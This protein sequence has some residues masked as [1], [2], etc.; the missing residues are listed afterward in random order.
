M[1][2]FTLFSSLFSS[3]RGQGTGRGRP[4][5]EALEDRQLLSSALYPGQVLYPGGPVVSSP[6]G[7]FQL[8]LRADGDLVEYGPY[9]D[10]LWESYTGGRGVRYATLQTDGNLVLYG[11]PHADGSL[12]AVKGFGTDHHPGDVLRVQD[13][14][15]VVI[16]QGGAPGGNPIWATNTAGYDADVFLRPGVSSSSPNLNFTLSLQYNGYLI[17]RG[18]DGL[19]IWDSGYHGRAIEAIVQS[20]GNFVMYGPNNPDGTAN[21]IWAT[22]TA[23]HRNS[24]LRVQDDGNMVLY[25]GSTPFWATNTVGR[26]AN[27]Y[28]RP[29]QSISSSDGWLRLTL[30]PEGNLVANYGP[31]ETVVFD[32]GVHGRAIEAILQTDGNLVLYGDANSQGYAQPLW[33]SNTAGHPGAR[34]VLEDRVAEVNGMLIVDSAGHAIWQNGKRL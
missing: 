7:N 17:L 22:N 28:L 1:T 3:R 24:R 30:K 8:A 18:P 34:L 2:L 23:G 33:A 12:N 16:Y 9:G 20:D 14:G 26:D 11:P 29:G 5:V 21:R 32:S 19:D 13:D 27:L 6:N 10:K 25:Q 15:N 4:A 31:F